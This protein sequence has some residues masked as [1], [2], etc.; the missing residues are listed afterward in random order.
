MKASS[1]GTAVST[2]Y[3]AV[4]SDGAKGSHTLTLTSPFSPLRQNPAHV[5]VITLFYL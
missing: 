1:D 3:C 4:C 5:D 2:G